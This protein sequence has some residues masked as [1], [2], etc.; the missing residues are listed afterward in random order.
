M[1]ELK[2]STL[3]LRILVIVVILAFAILLFL[4]ATTFGLSKASPSTGRAKG[5][6]TQLEL[7]LGV[8]RP[9]KWVRPVELV[10]AGLLGVSCFAV[11]FFNRSPK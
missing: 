2:L 9:T 5:C 4:D 10:G 7:L 8:K 11:V 1:P 6:Y 3:I